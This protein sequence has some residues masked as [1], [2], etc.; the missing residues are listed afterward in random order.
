MTQMI[1]RPVLPETS[2]STSSSA[3]PFAVSW[4]LPG[5][6]AVQRYVQERPQAP[7]LLTAKWLCLAG[8]VPWKDAIAGPAIRAL[9]RP[10]EAAGHSPPRDVLEL[11]D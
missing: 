11:P 3:V 2:R 1:P 5:C 4:K 9:V 8:P 6:R 7:G 10:A